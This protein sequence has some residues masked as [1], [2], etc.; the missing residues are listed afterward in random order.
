MS[1]LGDHAGIRSARRDARNLHVSSRRAGRIVDEHRLRAPGT[2]IASSQSPFRF[3]VVLS[4]ECHHARESRGSVIFLG[5]QRGSNLS[6]RGSCRHPEQEHRAASADA[7]SAEACPAGEDTRRAISA[8]VHE[9]AD[10]RQAYVLW[11]RRG[12]ER[13]SDAGRGAKP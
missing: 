8:S 1:S 2:A 9:G 11:G 5:L 7:S 13:Q 3:R 10:L 6:R 4:E 12:Y